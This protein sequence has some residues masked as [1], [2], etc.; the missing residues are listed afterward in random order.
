MLTIPQE[1]Y[2]KPDKYVNQT[3]GMWGEFAEPVK[4]LEASIGFWNKLG[5]VV[6]SKYQSPQPWAILSDGLA[7]IGLHQTTEFSEPTMT[8]FAA[9]MKDKLAKLKENGLEIY[10]EFGA[11]NAVVKT[12]ES[13][14]LNLFCFG[15]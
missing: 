15:M 10:K 12:P 8:F 11:K 3:I 2:F 14:Y 5:F 13:Q 6:L 1:D 7:I 4:D 9:D